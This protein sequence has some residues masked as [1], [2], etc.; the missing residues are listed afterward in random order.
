MGINHTQSLFIMVQ[1]KNFL[2]PLTQVD[3]GVGLNVCPLR[4]SSKLGFKAED[5][6]LATVDIPFW[7]SLI[8]MKP[9]YT[10]SC[11]IHL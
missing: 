10:I 3:N 7:H 5:I 11:F 1:Y 8:V 9:L 4:T 2:I 6:T